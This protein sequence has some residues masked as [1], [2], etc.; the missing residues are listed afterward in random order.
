MIAQSE[1]VYLDESAHYG[2]VQK[3]WE[4]FMTSR[5][6]K[7][8][9]AKRGVQRKE[10]IFSSTSVTAPIVRQH[11]PPCTHTMYHVHTLID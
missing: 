4:N 2:N 8:G 7:S 1:E 6:Q 11:T 3:G 10:R 9:L 5:T